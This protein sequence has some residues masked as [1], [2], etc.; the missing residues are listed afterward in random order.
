MSSFPL[1]FNISTFI[2]LYISSEIRVDAW[3]LC[4]LF[5]RAEPRSIEDIGTWYVILEIV[6]NSSIFINSAIVSFT[7]TNTINYTWVERIWIFILM[8]S[9]L[10]AIRNTVAFFI[11][12]V[13]AEVEI[14]L[15]RQEYIVGKVLDNVE[16][17][18]ENAHFSKTGYEI[19]SF[20]VAPTDD[21]PM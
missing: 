12:D 10:F 5:R 8:A 9:G 4:Q 14:Q 19:P 6:S 16:D 7:A 3:K 20:L 13:P 18:D 15:A 21:D 2:S 17:E 1:L 11:P